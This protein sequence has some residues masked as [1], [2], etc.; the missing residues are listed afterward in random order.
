MIKCL[1]TV[2]LFL[3]AMP[4][5]AFE[6]GREW[7]NPTKDYANETPIADTD[8][9]EVVASKEIAAVVTYLQ[10]KAFVEISEDVA[11][12]YTGHYFKRKPGQKTYLIRAVNANGGTGRYMVFRKG[13][14][15]VVVQGSLGKLGEPG[16][17]A[18]IVNLNFK[19]DK[20]YISA[21]SA[22]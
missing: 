10:K 21:G 3:I 1:I 6:N 5:T 14:S 15:L 7:L 16:K 11:K 22:E 20:V 2:F 18:L 8:I 12:S 4:A 17:S 19:P 9:Y 13:Y